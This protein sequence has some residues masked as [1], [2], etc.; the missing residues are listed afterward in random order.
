M[1][2]ED[3]APILIILFWISFFENLFSYLSSFSWTFWSHVLFYRLLYLSFPLAG[4][5]LSLFLFHLQHVLLYLLLY[6]PVH[7]SPG[8]LLLSLFLL[9][10]QLFLLLLCF[11][12]AI[13]FQCDPFFRSFC[14]QLVFLFLSFFLVLLIEASIFSLLLSLL[15]RFSFFLSFTLL[16]FLGF[17]FCTSSVENTHIEVQS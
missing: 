3:I 4:L 13:F 10:L 5:L 12:F 8:L 15:A 11:H 9:H 2:V 1:S 17:S 7:P 16:S 14:F 6:F